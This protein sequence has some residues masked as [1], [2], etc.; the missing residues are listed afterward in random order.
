MTDNCSP[1][2]T[3][4]GEGVAQRGVVK[5]RHGII[6]TGQEPKRKSDETPGRDEEGMQST[7][8]RVI[9][10]DKA[11]ALDKISRLD[12]GDRYRFDHR[13][14]NIKIFGRVHENSEPSLYTQLHL[15][16]NA[17]EKAA[18]TPSAGTSKPS[19]AAATGSSSKTPAAGSSTTI[20]PRRRTGLTT[21]RR[22][23]LAK[24]SDQD[25]W[26]ILQTY[27]AYAREHN[28]SMRT[29]WNR[30]AIHELA[31]DPRK[32]VESLEAQKRLFGLSAEDSDSE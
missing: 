24:I 31:Q 14:P 16:F 11:T 3:Y 12:Y 23:G 30:E 4:N 22:L 32:R 18:R 26:A 5:S 27:M 8:I 19:V 7:A 10:Y 20:V 25:M 2:K 21:T 9:P 17:I 15:V 29:Q 13:V 6:Y 1:I 28:H